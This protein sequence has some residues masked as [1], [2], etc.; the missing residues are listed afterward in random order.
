MLIENSW[1]DYEGEQIRVTASFG[2]TLSVED[3]TAE[4]IVGRAD[5]QV[6]ISKEAGRNCVHID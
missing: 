6:Y 2:G 1:I 5:A 4:A 3:D